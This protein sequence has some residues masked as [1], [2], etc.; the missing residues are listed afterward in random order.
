M[1]SGIQA[2]CH[3][4]RLRRRVTVTTIKESEVK[5][6][7]I[8]FLLLSDA[9]WNHHGRL[10]ADHEKRSLSAFACRIVPLTALRG[11]IDANLFSWGAVAPV[12]Y[13]T[14]LFKHTYCCSVNGFPTSV[15]SWRTRGGDLF[16]CRAAVRPL[17][18]LYQQRGETRSDSDQSRSRL[19]IKRNRTCNKRS[20]TPPHLHRCAQ[21]LQKQSCSF[22]VSVLFSRRG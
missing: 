18:P 16:T 22:K 9:S 14:R 4:E 5:R 6:I 15:P 10:H 20:F 3:G 17:H 7:H 21:A 1:W 19:S 8:S 2:Q 12:I 13:T 11:V